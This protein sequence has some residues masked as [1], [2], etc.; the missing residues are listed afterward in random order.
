[1]KLFF[2]ILFILLA[3]VVAT[4][5]AVFLFRVSLTEITLRV[6]GIQDP[7][8]D[9]LSFPTP[10]S[11]LAEGVSGELGGFRISAEEIRAALSGW[12]VFGKDL[13]LSVVNGTILL[14]EKSPF[15]EAQDVDVPVEDSETPTSVSGF[16]L[17]AF[18]LVID[19]LQ[20]VSPFSDN[21]LATL[22]FTSSSG[23]AK[24]FGG[25]GEIL[26]IAF[27]IRGSGNNERLQADLDWSS[28]ASPNWDS[29]QS[30]LELW[31]VEAPP[32]FGAIWENLNGRATIETDSKDLVSKI[33]ST[34]VRLE[35]E[36]E[37]FGFS[38]EDGM[39]KGEISQ[40]SEDSRVFLDAEAKT[41]T[42]KQSDIFLTA[43]GFSGSMEIDPKKTSYFIASDSGS[44]VI[45]GIE[46]EPF[47]FSA[48]LSQESDA[49]FAVEVGASL[50]AFSGE[51]DADVSL[52]FAETVDIEAKAAFHNL[53]LRTLNNHFAVFDGT[54][55]AQVQGEI[56]FKRESGFVTVL[57]SLIEM[58][59]DTIGRLSF[60]RAGWMTG[61]PELDPVKVAEGL[62]IDQLL[63]REDGTQ[64][65]VELAARDLTVTLLRISLFQEDLDERQ[66]EIKLEGYSMV[67]GTRIPL[68][69]TIPLRG[70]LQETIRIL[71]QA[72][73][74]IG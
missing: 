42:W 22:S 53:D 69:L 67:K 11:L 35:K 58:V 62:R 60:T 28:V 38:A 44:G 37:A 33:E 36:W 30:Q 45:N 63:S 70:Q 55:D 61:D 73:E 18:G 66:G 56:A 41:F 24:E 23:I 17:P 49:P 9:Q 10:L 72:A 29:L 50:T 68:V 6:V 59:P 43:F 46:I 71:L 40:N 27:E 39:L 7:E 26:S 48:D 51:I 3:V 47:S 32:F 52:R 14:S 12:Q 13:D 31:K 5:F 54:V 65:L 74:I 21:P 25:R 2:R 34:F 16:Q 4:L 64:I 1:M 19:N 57:P 8:V 20:I 15:S